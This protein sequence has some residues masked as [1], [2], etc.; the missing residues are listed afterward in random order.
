M[1]TPRALVLCSLLA[2]ALGGCPEKPKPQ[3]PDQGVRKAPPKKPAVDPAIADIPLD[4]S[5][6]D[7]RARW[8]RRP[9]SPP[10][11]VAVRTILIKHNHAKGAAG[12]TR[13]KAAAERRAQRLAQAARKKGADFLALARRYSEVPAPQRGEVQVLSPGQMG[14]HFDAMAFGMGVGQ[15]SDAFGTRQGFFVVMRVEPEEYSSA[16]ILIQYKGAKVAPIAIT[17]TKEEAAKLAKT[18]RG[19]AVKPD[20]NFAVL[21]ARYSDS[22]SR[23]GGGVLRPMAPGQMP[24]DYNPYIDALRQLKVGDISEVVETPFGFHIIKRLKLERI[25]ASHILLSFRGSEGDAKEER[26][27]HDAEVLGRKLR[28]Q[29]AAAGADFAALARKYSD[30]TESAEKGGDLGSFARGMMPQRFEQIAFAL[31]VGQ[32]SDLVETPLG[33]HIILRTE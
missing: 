30:H 7:D 5:V 24:A 11:Q 9:A 8:P 29:A 16:H 10:G 31:K 19:L 33:F 18:A 15:V 2:L 6:P 22:P 26:S 32:V 23:I 25:R 17:R 12:V 13:D 27:R 1:R 20:A 3:L 4:S 14:K 21:A 28:T